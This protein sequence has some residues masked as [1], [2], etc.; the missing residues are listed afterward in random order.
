MGLPPTGNGEVMEKFEELRDLTLSQAALII[1]L[2]RTSLNSEAREGP[3]VFTISRADRRGADPRKLVEERVRVTLWCEFP[4]GQHPL[5]F[6]GT[7][8]KADGEYVVSAPRELIVRLAPYLRSL[9]SVARIAMPVSMPTLD[10]LFAER[11]RHVVDSI[12]EMEKLIQV[13][14]DDGPHESA[15]RAHADYRRRTEVDGAALREFHVFL[16]KQDPDW[17][18][19]GLGR[20]QSKSGEYLWLCGAHYKLYDPG[21]PKL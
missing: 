20:A 2:F 4:D 10:A 7:G 21:L 9:A 16:E 5:C 11:A 13:A 8:G 1:Q 18:W 19:G 14:A 12:D 6:P 17:H 15:E 3:R